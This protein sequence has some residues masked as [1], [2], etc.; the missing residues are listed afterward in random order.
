MRAVNEERLF[1]LLPYFFENPDTVLIEIAQN[2][3]R[4]GAMKLDINLDRKTRVLSAGDN[5]MGLDHPSSLFV[6]AES[7]WTDKVEEE[8]MPAGWG[9]FFLYSIAEKVRFT[10]A[11][12]SVD[13]DCERYL[14]NA[15][16]RENILVGVCQE[17]SCDGF[18][19]EA[20]LKPGVAEKIESGVAKLSF[21]EMETSFNNGIVLGK[22]IDKSIM[23][24][25]IVRTEYEGN[26]VWIN[27]LR[28]A[29]IKRRTRE[30][31][32]VWYGIPIYDYQTFV[33][34]AAIRVTSGSPL[35]P[36]LPYRNAVKSDEKYDAFCEYIRGVAVDYCTTQINGG[37][38][39]DSRLLECMSVMEQI[40]TQKELDSLDRFSVK[41]WDPYS[42]DNSLHWGTP[43]GRWILKRDGDTVVN[44]V[45]VLR[46]LEEY[47][48]QEGIGQSGYEEIILPEGTI[49]SFSLP[50]NRPEW[51]SSKIEDKKVTISVGPH[52]EHKHSG[53]L[54]LEWWSVS[55]VSDKDI[56]VLAVGSYHGE[57]IICY[58]GV[59]KGVYTISDSIFNQL[60]FREDM[61][62]E[63]VDSHESQQHEFY[64]AVS[65][66]IQQITGSYS[67][68]D[69][70]G[71]MSVAGISPRDVLNLNIEN[72]IL[73]VKTKAGEVALNL[74]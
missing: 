49:T 14:N 51:L 48:E 69:L 33:H 29:D 32:V 34:A 61:G 27:P 42:H 16:Y 62:C 15:S 1:S 58:Q 46:G 52:L 39:D 2:A 23:G 7:D 66:D 74:G 11:F 20:V 41:K 50:D 40:A 44:E 45:L 67:L 55:I 54:G 22:P 59:P 57:G 10:S 24:D 68:Q 53:E 12:G 28:C 5:G 60:F 19:L 4:S 21:F 31:F 64:E 43:Y 18:L 9:L 26:E 65:K 3:K 47:L 30:I 13:V 56:D 70:L 8:Q 63:D 71:G 6:L 37:E 36:V 35:T 73:T 72:N 25:T 17:D 38:I